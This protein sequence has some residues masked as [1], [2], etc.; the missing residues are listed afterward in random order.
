[1]SY[2]IELTRRAK[3]EILKLD[4][5]IFEQIK[6]AI[7]SFCVTILRQKVQLSSSWETLE[8]WKLDDVDVANKSTPRV[9]GGWKSPSVRGVYLLQSCAVTFTVRMGYG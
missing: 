7:D 3:K 5:A 4:A 1:M 2:E 6:A 8:P 9:F